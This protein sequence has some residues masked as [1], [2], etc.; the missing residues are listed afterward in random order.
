MLSSVYVANWTIHTFNEVRY[1][2]DE[3]VSAYQLGQETLE[4][5]T[6]AMEKE[7]THWFSIVDHY[8]N[9]FKEWRMVNDKKRK[10][11]NQKFVRPDMS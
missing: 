1:S 9:L 10:R 5:L 8:T 11:T 7:T 3:N 2:L 6:D 4:F